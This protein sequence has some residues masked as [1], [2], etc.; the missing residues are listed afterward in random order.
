ML[1]IGLHGII[2][3]SRGAPRHLR[4]VPGYSKGFKDV[5]GALHEASRA[6]KGVLRKYKGIS[7]AFHGVSE[8]LEA[9]YRCSI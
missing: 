1:F 9:F 5:P 7:Q 2:G 3:V 4:N 6:L 8:V